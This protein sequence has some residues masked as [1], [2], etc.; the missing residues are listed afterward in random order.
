MASL[1]VAR[2]QMAL[3]GEALH[4]Q[5]QVEAANA[6]ELLCRGGIATVP[7]AEGID[8]LRLVIPSAQFGLSGHELEEAVRSAGIMLEYAGLEHVLAIFSI[9]DEHGTGEVFARKIVDATREYRAHPHMTDRL[10]AAKRVGEWLR[11][12]PLPVAALKPRSAWL[13][14]SRAR[15][16]LHE[17]E[18]KV[19]AES[20]FPYPPGSPVLVQGEIVPEGFAEA[21]DLMKTAGVHFQGPSDPSLRTMQVLHDGTANLTNI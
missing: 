21:V 6:R 20:F 19:A 3:H 10:A 2:R 11:K 16:P 12:Q 17:A 5:A 15:V 4:A 9:H 13:A 14:D 8:P 7:E 18:G 1:D